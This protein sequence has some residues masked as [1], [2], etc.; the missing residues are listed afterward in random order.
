MLQWGTCFTLRASERGSGKRAHGARASS[1]GEWDP[2]TGFMRMKYQ[3]R[4]A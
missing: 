3:E 2:Q 1:G 4:A